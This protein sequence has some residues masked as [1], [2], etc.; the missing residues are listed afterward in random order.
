MRFQ[1]G[2]EE[3]PRLASDLEHEVFVAG[4]QD[5]VGTAVRW[6]QGRRHWGRADID[7]SRLPQAL[8]DLLRRGGDVRVVGHAGKQRIELVEKRDRQWLRTGE[9]LPW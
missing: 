3:R 8:G 1:V 4:N 2:G 6:R 9:E 5:A 7:K